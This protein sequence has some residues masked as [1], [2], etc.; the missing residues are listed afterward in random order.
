MAAAT[1]RRRLAPGQVGTDALLA[2]AILTLAAITIVAELLGTFGYFR[3]RYLMVAYLLV[4]VTGWGLGRRW[5]QPVAEPSPAPGNQPATP[6]ESALAGWRS[7][8]MIGALCFF[9]GSW[10][11]RTLK[12]VA[13]GITTAD[14][15]WYHL[16]FAIR[17]AQTG[18]TSSIQLIDSDSVTAY[19]PATG[20]ILHALGMVFFRTDLLSTVINLGWLG[21]LLLA[22]WCAGRPFGVAPVSMLGAAILF[23]GPGMV[24]TQ[25]GGALTDVMGVALLLAAAAIAIGPRNDRAMGPDLLAALA[26][27]LA[28]GAKFT[29]LPGAIV[30]CLGLIVTAPRGYRLRRA[31][32]VSGAFTLAGGYWYLRNWLVVGNPLPTLSLG[33]GPLQLHQVPGTLRSTSVAS[34]V[35]DRGAWGLHLLPGFRD[36]L[37]P[38]WP[39]ILLVSVAGA[40]LAVLRGP[41]SRIRMLGIVALVCNLAYFV[42]PQ[43][44]YGGIFFATNL[45]YAAP[46]IAL[47]LVLFPI[48]LRDHRRWTLP[49]F[50]GVLVA[51]QL[52]PVSWPVPFGGS[53]FFSSIDRSSAWRGGIAAL[54]LVTMTVGA[55]A[56]WRLTPARR[57]KVPAATT[58]I[59]LA[60]LLGFAGI[61]GRYLEGRY[62]GTFGFPNI[63]EYV[64]NVHHA[65]IGVNGQYV[66]LK[67][68]FA[69]PDL[70][71]RVQYLGV[72]IGG[73]T[74]RPPATCEE[75]IALLQEGRYDYVIVLGSPASPGPLTW[76]ASQ[77]DAR[78]VARDG[79]QAIEARAYR[80]DSTRARRCE[81]VPPG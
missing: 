19:F 63:Y 33:L 35:T 32:G 73:G 30:L 27:G 34:L 70:T 65:N 9:V 8:L 44:L 50:A 13:H 39:L 40:I 36:A 59:A 26:A 2:D 5:L 55:W 38:V 60:M 46:G 57:F 42:M 51:T 80:L 14:S 56:L 81:P 68:P 23:G 71:N 47:G 6:D 7:V 20:S 76:T 10:L 49:A 66:Y 58:A 17:F 52:D 21:L 62:R 28:T 16:P 41:G 18:R 75:W 77:P 67:S 78:L 74:W 53:S 4:G 37:G 25:P 24:E 54:I 43:Y 69:G 3:L 79:T 11:A 31:L 1:L 29:F 15:L 12:A 72:D 64:R 22:A 48:V 61:H 45:R